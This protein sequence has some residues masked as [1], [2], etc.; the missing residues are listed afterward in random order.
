MSTERG[1]NQ[2]LAIKASIG[3]GQHWPPT[4]RINSN[5]D[6]VELTMIK[7]ECLCGEVTYQVDKP[8]FNSAHCHCSMCRRQH[9]AAFTTYA[10]FQPDSF[11]WTSGASPVNTYELETGGGWCFCKICGSTLAGTDKGK[12]KSIA[13]GTATGDPGITP[14]IHIFTGSKAGWYEIA[15][16]LPQFKE[17]P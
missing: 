17:R 14:E 12:T 11:S 13:L 3:D 7:V 6:F 10:A 15:D 16:K 5:Y 2:V 8:L 9:G 1:Q 4:F